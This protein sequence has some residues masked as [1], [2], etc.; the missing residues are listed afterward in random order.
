M[1]SRVG[2][3]GFPVGNF[4]LGN[5]QLSIA[6]I[7]RV[8]FTKT[9]REGRQMKKHIRFTQVWNLR[10]RLGILWLPRFALGDD[11]LSHRIDVIPVIFTKH[12][13]KIAH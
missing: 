10:I 5:V 9:F 11:P 7:I 8:M 12:P 4:A 1:G 3:E 2:R 13:K 6:Y